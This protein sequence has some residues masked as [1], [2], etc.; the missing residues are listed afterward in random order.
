MSSMIHAMASGGVDGL[1]TTPPDA[2]AWIM[3]DIDLVLIMTKINVRL[4]KLIAAQLRKIERAARYRAYRRRECRR[5]RP[6]ASP[7]AQP[8]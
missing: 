2:I 1:R 7:Q 8:R 6:P 4:D 5:Q 3:D